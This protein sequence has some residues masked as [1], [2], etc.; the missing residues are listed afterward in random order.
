M[1]IVHQTPF[2]CFK[3]FADYL[4]SLFEKYVV[5]FIKQGIQEVVL[6]F[7]YQN[8]KCSPKDFV[9]QKRDGSL[10][11]EKFVGLSNTSSIPLNWTAFIKN[12]KNK[13]NFIELI[14]EEFKRIGEIKL[15]NNNTL[16]LSGTVKG[17]STTYFFTKW[18]HRGS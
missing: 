17:K 16:I 13:E 10:S 2:K 6:A 15:K 18:N 5:T 11:S 7:D 1:F 9:R 3:T 4:T 12:R 14:I 8:Y